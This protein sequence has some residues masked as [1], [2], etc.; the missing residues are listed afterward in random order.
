MW[1]EWY[2]H[3]KKCNTLWLPGN[4]SAIRFNGFNR[5]VDYRWYTGDTPLEQPRF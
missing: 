2:R 4:V 5:G 3:H 1:L